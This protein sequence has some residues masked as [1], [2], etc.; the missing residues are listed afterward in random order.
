MQLVDVIVEVLDELGATDSHPVHRQRFNPI[1][2]ARWKKLGHVIARG[3][4]FGQE[5][6]A[7]LQRYS[8]DAATWKKNAAKGRTAHDLFKMHGGGYWSVRDSAIRD[9]LSR[10]F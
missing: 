4:D 5:V 10:F 6:S 3:S 7:E 2:E 9:P 1:I 8:S